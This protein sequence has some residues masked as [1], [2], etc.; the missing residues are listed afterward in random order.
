MNEEQKI[1]FK[2]YITKK[3]NETLQLELSLIEK[4][5]SSNQTTIVSP[6]YLPMRRIKTPDKKY[7]MNMNS[8]RNRDF[9]TSNNLKIR[10]KEVMEDHLK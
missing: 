9:I 3:R 4:N 7:S 10:Y 5:K 6:M 1:F 2:D 8:Y